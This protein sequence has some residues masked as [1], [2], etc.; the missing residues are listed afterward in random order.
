MIDDLALLEALYEARETQQAKED[1]ERLTQSLHEFVKAAFHVVKP[2]REFRDNWHIQAI[3]AHLEAVTE[4]EINR[5]QAHVPPGTMK[6][7]NV[8]VFWPVWEWT[9][10]PGLRY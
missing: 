1:R 3:D 4:G 10:N 6:S 9:R 2:E 8:S 5:L 7:M